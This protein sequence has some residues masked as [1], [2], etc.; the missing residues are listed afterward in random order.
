MNIDLLSI[1]SHEKFVVS[2][3]YTEL[4]HNIGKI[5]VEISGIKAEEKSIQSQTI[6][7]IKRFNIQKKGL[8][9]ILKCEKEKKFLRTKYVRLESK[10]N[11]KL[12]QQ[13]KLLKRK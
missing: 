13:V 2:K 1:F 5:C 10:N 8:G 3:N 9:T 4:K 7:I 12:F 6:A 11:V